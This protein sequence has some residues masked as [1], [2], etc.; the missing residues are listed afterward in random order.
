MAMQDYI[1][2]SPRD[3]LYSPAALV[4]IRRDNPEHFECCWKGIGDFGEFRFSTF[5]GL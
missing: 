3:G 5:P 2:Y 1:C 4:D